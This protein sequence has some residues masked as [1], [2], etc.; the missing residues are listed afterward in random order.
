MKTIKK[1]LLFFP[2]LDFSAF[3]FWGLLLF[4]YWATGE[5]NRLIH[6]NYFL[7]V[8]IASV[9]LFIISSL[10]VLQIYLRYYRKKAYMRSDNQNSILL[11]PKGW[12]SSLLIAV[13]VF[14]LVTEPIILNSQSAIQRGLVDSLP[15]VTLQLES[16]GTGTKPEERTII[17]WVRTLH[18]YPEPDT[19]KG[20]K[21]NI[22]GFVVHLDSL[23]DD[24]VYLSRFII[25]C[26]AVDAYP[27]G[28]P[29]KLPESRENYPPDTWLTIQG[30]MM[31]QILPPLDATVTD[32]R[33]EVRHLVL[34]ASEVEII[35]TPADPY[36]Y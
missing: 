24:Y 36:G 31:T 7:L 5:L 3:F 12:G 33:R 8:F 4:K 29:V 1:N 6:P 10:K 17:E 23:P 11:L 14:G 27:V 16:F 22:T 19:Y 18:V 35:P 26:C 15:P 28:I 20:Q 25:T 13:A 34:N 9:V 32:T 30:E 2:L 21:A